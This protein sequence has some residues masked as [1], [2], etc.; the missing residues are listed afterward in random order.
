M[1]KGTEWGGRRVKKS[2]LASAKAL[3]WERAYLVE[4]IERKMGV[5]RKG[6]KRETRQGPVSKV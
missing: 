6:M 3:R 1:E 5:N 4:G 2:P